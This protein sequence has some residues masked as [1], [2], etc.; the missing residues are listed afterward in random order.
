MTGLCPADCGYRDDRHPEV[1]KL[2][3]E[4]YA[5]VNAPPFVVVLPGRRNSLDVVQHNQI[6]PE[7]VSRRGHV[8]QIIR[9]LT[10]CEPGQELQL[11]HHTNQHRQYSCEH[12]EQRCRIRLIQSDPENDVRTFQ[13]DQNSCPR[14]FILPQVRRNDSVLNPDSPHDIN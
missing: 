1:G 9:R 11:Q 4:V 12:R 5:D 6:R 3:N 2:P 7:V 14:S 10:E 8:P 13:P